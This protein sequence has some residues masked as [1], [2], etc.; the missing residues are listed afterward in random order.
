[1]QG[2]NFGVADTSPTV[3]IGSTPCVSVEWTSISSLSC[4]VGKGTGTALHVVVDVASTYSTV[5]AV[6]S[7]DSPVVTHGS[8][9]NAATSG[10]TTMTIS[11]VNFASCNQVKPHY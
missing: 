9:P 3:H 7:Y 8:L 1:M 6:F 4:S 5:A 10:T 11:G 2:H